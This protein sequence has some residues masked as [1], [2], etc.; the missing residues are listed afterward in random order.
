MKLLV[1]AQRLD[2]DES[3][4]NAIA[5][6]DRLR[7]THGYDIVLHATDGPAAQMVRDRGFRFVPAPDVAYHPAPQRMAALRRLVR[8]EGPDVIH[9]W[10]GWQG[11]EA[12]YAVHLRLGVPLLIS[13][14]NADVTRYLPRNVPTTFD[15]AA[16]TEAAAELGWRFPM[17][18][19]MPVD[20]RTNAAE[21]VNGAGFRSRYGLKDG[22]VMIAAVAERPDATASGG[23]IRAIEAIRTLGQNLPLKLVL[24]G[25]SD[26]DANLRA[27]VDAANRHLYRE[28]VILTGAMP[29]PR[30]A[31]AAADIVVG[32]GGSAL[33]GLAFGKP[34]VVVGAA[35]F[36]AAFTRQTAP[37]FL[38]SG[39][40][41]TGEGRFGSS[42][43]LDALRPLAQRPQ[44]RAQLGAFGRD[45]VVENHDL[46][47]VTAQLAAC[48][49]A[50]KSG[51]ASRMGDLVDAARTAFYVLRERRFRVAARTTVPGR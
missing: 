15:C 23:T 24:L 19:P 22:D 18:L 51:A 29:D 43:M 42:A 33:R 6:A 50:A 16:L 40:R 11:L 31:Y 4:M 7:E 20:T 17:T 12:Y 47:R 48:C 44:L 46:C 21:A 14:L 1:F 36:A 38:R 45:F 34:L 35:G 27:R 5:L 30:E 25:E 8:G 49:T 32:T 9:A 39:M 28:A 41:G 13:D 26:T 37:G 10:D 2:A 3:Q